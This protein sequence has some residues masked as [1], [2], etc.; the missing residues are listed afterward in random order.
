MNWAAHY[1][2]VQSDSGSLNWTPKRTGRRQHWLRQR[3]VC[4]AEQDSFAVR[5]TAS[6]KA[7]FADTIATEASR[8]QT[9]AEWKTAYKVR[10]VKQCK[11]LL[12]R[13]VI[14][15]TSLLIDE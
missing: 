13:L 6:A 4:V 15:I 10:R 1:Q 8:S 7:K 11:A 9:F 14:T 2:A 5:Q 12:A 3:V